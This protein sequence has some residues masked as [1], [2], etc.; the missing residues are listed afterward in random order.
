[1]E[2][3]N[4]REQ[5]LKLDTRGRI[6]TPSDRRGLLLEEFDRSGMSGVQFAKWAGIKY[7]TWAGWV[8]QRKAAKRKMP[9]TVEPVRAKPWVE[10]VVE[11]HEVAR[12]CSPGQSGLL[13]HTSTGLRLELS[14]EQHVAW[15]AKLLRHLEGSRP[16]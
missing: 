8:R 3:E 15:A 10:G 2:N 11:R 13:V 1:M 14:E 9:V 12:P 4:S 7:T 5:I 16:C 6:K